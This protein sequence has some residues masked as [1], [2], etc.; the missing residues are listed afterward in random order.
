MTIYLDNAATSHPKPPEVY[1]AV[2]DAMQNIG[3]S[4]GRGGYGLALDASRLLFD[5]RELLAGFFGAADSSRIIF[6][7]NATEALNLAVRGLLQPGD[8]VVTSSMEHNSLLRP[9]FMLEQR[10]VELTIV[11]ADN[12]GLIN[13]EDVRQALRPTTRLVALSHVSNVTGGI[14]PI[15]EIAAIARA[16]GALML[17][18]AAQSA[19]CLEIDMQALGI[20]LLAAPG[21]KGLLGPQGTGLLAVAPC[22]PLRP[23]LAG[24]TGNSSDQDQQPDIF[25][26]G[27]EA[28]THNLPGIAGL[29]AGVTFLA[30][31]GVTAVGR[32]EH[33]CGTYLRER[34]TALPGCRLHGPCNPAQR[35]GL[36]SVTFEAW[37]SAALAFILDREYGIATRAGL[38]C[39]PRAH[40]TIGT[41]PGG[42]LRIS[43]GWFTTTEELD[44]CYTAL[45]T[46]IQKGS[47]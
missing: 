25:P 2:L 30:A 45:A 44:R 15:A 21:H 41:Y 28:G 27:F 39:A 13:P 35:V 46:T 23:L 6:T 20:D 12:E 4:P 17:L 16:G 36:F 37:D 14:Q 43:P 5:T 10:G 22:V 9:L 47:P 11:P 18:D 1:A 8:H 29:Y 32:H 24:G 40:R 34:L 38:H 3:A 31:N 19:G 26:E 7:R 33:E 42:T